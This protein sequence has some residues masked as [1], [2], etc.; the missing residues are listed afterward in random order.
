AKVHCPCTAL[1]G[2]TITAPGVNPGFC[3]N[4]ESIPKQW[5]NNNGKIQNICGVERIYAAPSEL[6]GSGY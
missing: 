3:R 5:Q 4:M 1:K 6:V 2:P